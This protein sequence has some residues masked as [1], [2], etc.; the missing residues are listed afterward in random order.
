MRRQLLPGMLAVTAVVLPTA[1]TA[2]VLALRGY[3]LDRLDA[4]L[5]LAAHLAPSRIEQAG[6]N[7][8]ALITPTEYVIELRRT[9]GTTTHFGAATGIPGYV[10][11]DHAPPAPAGGGVSKP[12]D[13]AANTYRAVVTRT[14]DGST[15]LV[16]LPLG[17]MHDTVRRL[18]LVEIG[19][20]A[21]PRTR[22]AAWPL[23]SRS[24]APC[25][26][27]SPP[28]PAAPRR[29]TC[30]RRAPTRPHSAPAAP[31]APAR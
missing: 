8:R 4:Q 27:C 21:A 22:L 10:L 28:S 1:G 31:V 2:A 30:R 24:C 13:L 26:T 14:T 25:P 6:V 9:D 15:V 29:W 19:T 16:A 17:P 3:L 7:V 11:L 18:A 20:G 23:W 12:V 5:A